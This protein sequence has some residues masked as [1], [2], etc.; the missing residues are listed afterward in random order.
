MTKKVLYR[1]SKATW[2][3]SPTYSRT[4]TWAIVLGLNFYPTFTLSTSPNEHLLLSTNFLLSLANQGSS[5]RQIPSPLPRKS[6]SSWKGVRWGLWI[7]GREEESLQMHPWLGNTRCC[8]YLSAW[9]IYNSNPIGNKYHLE[10]R[11]NSERL[12]GYLLRITQLVKSSLPFHPGIANPHTI[13]GN[14]PHSN[15]ERK[16]WTG[17][18]EFQIQVLAQLA[19]KQDRNNQKVQKE[20][21]HTSKDSKVCWLLVSSSLDV[22]GRVWPFWGLWLYF[23]NC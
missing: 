17:N 2:R 6:L 7:W 18:S 8:V 19:G 14:S 23:V 12:G 11:W 21:R 10:G 4:W 1:L 5:G 9:N 20:A 22:L 13:Q 15:K 3:I 16:K